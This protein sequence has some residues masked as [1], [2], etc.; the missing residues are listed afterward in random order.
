MSSITFFSS[1]VSSNLLQYRERKICLGQNDQLTNQMSA[2]NMSSGMSGTMMSQQNVAM[3]Q[4][5][6]MSGV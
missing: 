5:M 2:M 3:Q 1:F 4:K 6:M